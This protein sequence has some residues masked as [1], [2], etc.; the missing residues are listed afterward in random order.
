MIS[1]INRG[2]EMKN[3]MKIGLI[4]FLTGVSCGA[5]G[6]LNAKAA[7]LAILF[8]PLIVALLTVA[9]EEL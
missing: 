1:K 8:I 2:G 4:I 3:A 5:I 6:V 9:S 7:W